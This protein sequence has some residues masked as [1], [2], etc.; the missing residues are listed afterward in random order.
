MS[1]CGG[2]L[3]NVFMG[4][5]V[6]LLEAGH[7]PRDYT[8]GKVRIVRILASPVSIVHEKTNDYKRLEIKS[9]VMFLGQREIG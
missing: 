4:P 1:S 5:F 2:L 8:I 6:L 9:A 3:S 7:R